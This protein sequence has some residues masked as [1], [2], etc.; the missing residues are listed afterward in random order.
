MIFNN[1]LHLTNL[2]PV[3]ICLAVTNESKICERIFQEFILS[4]EILYIKHPIFRIVM[5]FID[6]WN[7]CHFFGA[8]FFNY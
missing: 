7:I 2:K 3:P 4:T 6:G 5:V 8:Y 1:R